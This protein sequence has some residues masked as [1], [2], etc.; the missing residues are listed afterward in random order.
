M[1]SLAV[2][3]AGGASEPV[4]GIVGDFRRVLRHV[5]FRVLPVFRGVRD[6]GGVGRRPDGFGRVGRVRIRGSGFGEGFRRFLF[7]GGVFLFPR[8][9]QCEQVR[10]GQVHE[11][12]GDRPAQAVAERLP[13]GGELGEG[14]ERGAARFVRGVHEQ[15]HGR[16]HGFFGQERQH[17]FAVRRSLDE[18]AVR[19]QGFQRAQQAAGAS[20]PVMADAKE[21]Y[22]LIRHGGAFF[23]GCIGKGCGVAPLS[24]REDAASRGSVNPLRG[25][26]GKGPSSR[27]VP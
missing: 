4:E 10:D 7:R 2:A 22:G 21:A 18:Q 5:V 15:G 24:S 17:G 6:S 16:A 20:R 3:V 1:A 19:L 27:S 23:A 26:R 12:D 8:L 13:F 11:P 14:V 25:R 9:V